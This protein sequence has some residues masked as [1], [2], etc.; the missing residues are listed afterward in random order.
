MAMVV[1]GGSRRGVG[2]TALVCGLIAV[3][4]E[5]RWTA[6]KVTT[7]N[8]GNSQPL[9]EET[10]PGQGTDTARYLAAGAQRAFLA[11]PAL[12]EGSF[13][14]NFPLLLAELWSKLGPGAHV[15]FESNRIVDYLKP[16]LSLVVDGGLGHS[17]RK[18]SFRI[19]ALHADAMVSHSDADR[20]I[21]G[22]E[23]SKPI[24][25]LAALERISAQ[26]EAW[27]RRR[28]EEQPGTKNK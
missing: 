16:D 19:A 18:A 28:L 5:I 23:Q 15:L 11:S 13:V 1:I 27:L 6:V 9:W 4:P 3:L 25:H 17:G 8:H 14:P 24:F 7:H 12:R 2:K 26:M 22:D 10:S 20:M 21:G